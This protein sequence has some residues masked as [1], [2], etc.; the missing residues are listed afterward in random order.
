MKYN[1][2]I[3]QKFFEQKTC[4]QSCHIPEDIQGI[5]ILHLKLCRALETFDKDLAY[6]YGNMSVWNVGL[7]LFIAYILITGHHDAVSMVAKL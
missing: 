3:D 5:H 4:Q 2:Q 1:F 7:G 6:Q